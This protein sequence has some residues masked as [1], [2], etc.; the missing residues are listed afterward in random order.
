VASRLSIMVK[1]HEVAVR[2]K[3]DTKGMDDG[4]HNER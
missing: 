3:T 2:E 4:R 1:R